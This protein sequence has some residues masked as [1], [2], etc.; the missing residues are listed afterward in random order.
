[1]QSHIRVTQ[2]AQHEHSRRRPVAGI[3]G[4]DNGF[5]RSDIAFFQDPQQFLADIFFD[6]QEKNIIN[7]TEGTASGHVPY[8]IKNIKG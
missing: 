2:C 4:D 8:G 3:A 6:D 7:S 1:M 5:V